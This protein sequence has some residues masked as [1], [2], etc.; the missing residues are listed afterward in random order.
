MTIETRFVGRIPE[1]Y[2]RHLGP[3]LFEPYARELA[4]RLP[5]GA[6]RVVEVAAGTGRLTR[7]L[8]RALPA[9]AELLVTDLNEPMLAI[10][11][12]LTGNDP[13]A[14]WQAA[15]AGALPV[16]DA[17]VDAVACGFGLM[18]VSDK[19]AVLREMKRVLVPG[20]VLLLDTWNQLALNPASQLL[21]QH[22]VAAFPADPPAFMLTPFSMS[23][24]HE[25]ERLATEAQFRG[26]RVE[27]VD[28]LGESE[29]AAHLAYGFVRGNPL[30]N[31]VSE[32]GIDADK[33]EADIAAALATR[34]GDRPCRT[35]LSALVLTA[36]A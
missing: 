6:R 25:L 26:V 12:E 21:H 28:K 22:A 27:T 9:D 2:D 13:R 5:Q 23:D 36:F 19:L 4:Q 20:G 35:P 7:Q 31:Q 17:S 30:W 33:L 14:R 29:S 10:A 16:P 8:L 15:D 3:N 11:R 18:F 24:A 32:R 34:F 1:L